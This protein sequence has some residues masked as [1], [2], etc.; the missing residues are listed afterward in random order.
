GIPHHRGL[1]RGRRR[2]IRLRA[3]LERQGRISLR[4]SRQ[5]QLHHYRHLERLPVRTG[6]RRRQLS[7]LI[8]Q[9]EIPS[10][11]PGRFPPPVFFL[12]AF[13]SEMG[14]GSPEENASKQEPRF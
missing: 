14:T 10:Q 6:A 8:Q 5:Q 7:L 1:D 9:Q 13:S 4:R 2:R 12:I 3:E 11:P